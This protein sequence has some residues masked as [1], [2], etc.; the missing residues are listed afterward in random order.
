MPRSPLLAASAALPLL[1]LVVSGC[2]AESPEKPGAA[3]PPTVSIAGTDFPAGVAVDYQ[4]GGAYDPPAGVGIVARDS[5]EQPASGVWSICYVNGFQTQPGEGD[6]WDDDLLLRD[7]SGEVVSDPEWPDENLLDTST[8]D[9]RQRIAAI[10]GEDITRCASKGFEAVEIDNLDS[11]TRADGITL[12]DNLAL[13]L[14]YAQRAHSTGLWIG[15]KNSA[16]YA[17]RLR[18]EV[19]F[20]F[21]VAEECVSY[22]ECASYSDVYGHAVIDIEYADDP[23]VSLDS[24]CSD[25]TRPASTVYRDRDLT[26]P[27]SADYVYAHC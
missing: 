5:T 10:L 17:S 26:T 9:K 2:T 15:Q 21:A 13:A 23:S 8:A 20:D 4:L 22:G 16:E 12:E 27:A 6:R 11:F 14:L 3:T 7:A 19:G 24:I 18:D 1:V 25:P